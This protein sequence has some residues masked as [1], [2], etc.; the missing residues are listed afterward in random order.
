M[1]FCTCR[2]VFTFQN[3]FTY[4]LQYVLMRLVMFFVYVNNNGVDQ[5]EELCSQISTFYFTAW[6]VYHLLFLFSNI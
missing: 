5:P 3:A 4:A 2:N 6:I 1:V